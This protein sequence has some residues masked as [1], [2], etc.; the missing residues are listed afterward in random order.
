VIDQHRAA[1][2]LRE[3]VQTIYTSEEC[4]RLRQKPQRPLPQPF[5]DALA[6]VPSEVYRGYAMDDREHIAALAHHVPPMAGVYT[7][8]FGQRFHP[9]YH[10]AVADWLGQASTA[11]PFPDDKHLSGGIEYA[12]AA[13]ALAAAHGQ[14]QFTVVELGAGFGPWTGFFGLMAKQL[15]F[16]RLN[17]AAFEADAGRFAQLRQHLALNGLVPA[18]ANTQGDDGRTHWQLF[19]AAAWW[20][21]GSV[22]WPANANPLD[23][24]MRAEASN[25]A[26]ADYRGRASALSKIPALDIATALAHLPPIDIAHID[27]QG[28]EA[29]LIPRQITFLN[30]TVRSLFIGTHSRQIEGDLMTLLYAQNWMLV[31]EK[32]CRFALAT[33]TPLLDGRTT[34][35][36]GQYW[37][38]RNP[39]IAFGHDPGWHLKRSDAPALPL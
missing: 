8:C 34:A 4:L 36:G 7:D 6:P 16:A 39:A 25:S 30:S 13:L 2:T 38:N 18:S 5:T 24:G 9:A 23:A 21:D 20:Q 10:P 35:D 14:P 15:G 17:L 29:E 31:R 11:L 3:L 28:S 32:P 33:H 26:T 19:N 1:A 22:F 37:V 27:L 12:A